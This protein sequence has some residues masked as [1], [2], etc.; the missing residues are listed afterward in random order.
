M[1]FIGVV[2]TLT[3]VPPL[4]DMY[5]RKVIFLATLF[6][7][8]VAQIGFIFSTSLTEAYVYE[9][10]LGTCFAGRTIIGLNYVLEYNLIQYTETIVTTFVF[11]FSID[12]ILLTAWY[13]FV[14][15]GWLQVQVILLV[16]ALITFAYFLV[17]VPESPKWQYIKGQFNRSRGNLAYVGKFNGLPETKLSRIRKIR[18]DIEVLEQKLQSVKSL[19]QDRPAINLEDERLSRQMSINDLQSQISRKKL[20]PIS[21]RQYIINVIIIAIMWTSASFCGYMLSF[22]NKYFEG[23]LFLNY[24]LDGL[25]GICGSLLSVAT[26]GCFGMR[27]AFVFSIALTLLGAVS[28]L[29]FE[30]GYLSPHFVHWFVIEKS[31]YERDTPED[32]EYYLGYLVPAIVFLTKT[33]VAITFQNTYQASFGDNLIFP[34]HKRNTAIGICN[35]IARCATILSSLAAELPRPWPALILIIISS[36]TLINSFFLPSKEEE[37]RFAELVRGKD[38]DA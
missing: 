26:Y 28:L 31:P 18:F 6:V 10:L 13:Q 33:G 25:S 23:S 37:R 17:L 4:S 8:I 22:M 38:K 30:Q 3:F 29:V 14:D 20:S 9:F 34:F 2:T 16:A 36:L 11:F 19:E 7:Q 27:Y 24:Y 1:Y 35:L 5:G 15:R 32:R 12:I 21:E